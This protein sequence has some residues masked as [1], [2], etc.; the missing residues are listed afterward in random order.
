MRKNMV[1]ARKK[2]GLLQE[3]VAN[4]IG[5]KRSTYTRYE[6]GTLTPTLNVALKIKKVLQSNDD[7]FLNS[8]V[9]KTN[10]IDENVNI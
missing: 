9:N 10:K 8:N 5:V 6:N 2:H 1:E 3:D 7:I 4:A